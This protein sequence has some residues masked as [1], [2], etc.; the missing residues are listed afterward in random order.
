MIINAVDNRTYSK[1]HFISAK[2]I[3][4]FIIEETAK[5]K[6]HNMNLVQRDFFL[7]ILWREIFQKET[8]RFKS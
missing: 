6:S 5:M 7:R 8:C 1:F 3:R 2:G 4:N